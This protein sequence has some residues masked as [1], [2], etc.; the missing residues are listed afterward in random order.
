MSLIHTPRETYA[1]YVIVTTVGTLAGRPIMVIWCSIVVSRYK[2]R[3][4]L[5][6]GLGIAG[7]NRNLP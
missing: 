6:N 4:V 1:N 7:A 5:W 2:K 3:F